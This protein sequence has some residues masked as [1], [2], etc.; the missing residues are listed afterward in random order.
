MFLLRCS[1]SSTN[2]VFL[3]IIGTVF[4]EANPKFVELDDMLKPKVLTELLAQETTG[5]I[6]S[7]M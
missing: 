1:N 4:S 2:F 3:V 7:T 5:G 6:M